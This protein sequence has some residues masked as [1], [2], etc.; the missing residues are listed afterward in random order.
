MWA[1]D[2]FFSTLGENAYPFPQR[3]GL[4]ALDDLYFVSTDA[5]AKRSLNRVNRNNQEVIAASRLK[6]T[7]HSIKSATPYPNPLANGQEGV[8]APRYS[9]IDQC[10]D[11]LD[12]FL[13]NRGA[14]GKATDEANYSIGLE[15]AYTVFIG[16]RHVYEYIARKQRPLHLLLTVAPTV[17]FGDGRQIVSDSATLKLMAHNPLVSRTSLNCV[18]VC[19]N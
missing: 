12:F 3:T 15:N 2:A 9:L 6:D 13:W 5:D 17:Y 19:R 10:S 14:F 1:H 4:T 11:R 18:P 16:R 8:R 7:L